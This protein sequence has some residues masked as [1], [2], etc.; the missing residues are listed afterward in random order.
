MPTLDEQRNASDSVADHLSDHN[1][2]HARYNEGGAGS[3]ES[4][5]DVATGVGLQNSWVNH[6]TYG[7]LEYRKH[8][9]GM[10]QIRGVVAAGSNGAVFTLP[11]GYRPLHTEL[12]VVTANLQSW[13]G[14]ASV[15]PD[16]TVNVLYTQNG[17][18]DSICLSRIFDSTGGS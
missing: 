17:A 7:D 18:K 15:A 16:G 5:I 2:L 12:F 3:W 10:V 11:T 6:A 9:D 1:L 8:T 14:S 4:W 13:T